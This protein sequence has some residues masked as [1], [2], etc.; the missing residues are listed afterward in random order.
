MR[1]DGETEDGD[2]AG[3]RTGHK[4][5]AA[6][7]AA[8]TG[9]EGGAVAVVVERVTEAEEMERAGLDAETAA[10]ALLAVNADETTI[11]FCFR[12]S[13]AFC[14]ASPCYKRLAAAADEPVSAGFTAR[15]NFT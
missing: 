4:A 11:W 2:G 14:H 1:R 12:F 13:G 8:G 6:T 7:G 3:L 9:I 15:A 10:L 5:D